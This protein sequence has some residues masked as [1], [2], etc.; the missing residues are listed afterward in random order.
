MHLQGLKDEAEIYLIAH[1]APAAQVFALPVLAKGRLWRRFVDT[2]LQP[3]SN[4]P[5]EEPVLANQASYVV[6]GDSLVVLA[7]G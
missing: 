6:S 3:A 2:A 4:T 1:A 5:G 7:G